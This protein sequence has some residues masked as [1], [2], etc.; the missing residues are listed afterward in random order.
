M[1]FIVK[2]TTFPGL[3][4]LLAP[5]SCRGCG[6]IGEAVCDRCKKYIVKN[7]H[8]FCP[9]CKKSNQN[10]KCPHCKILP[11]TFVVAER[12][13]L[14]DDLIHVYKYSSNRSLKKPLAELLSACMPR[15]FNHSVVIVPLP[16]ISSHIRTRGFDH[17]LLLAKNLAKLRHYKVQKLLLRKRN[18]VQVGADKKTRRLQA[19]EAYQINPKVKIK[20]D[21]TYLLIDDVW[22]TGASMLSAVKKLQQAGVSNIVI[23]ILAVSRLDN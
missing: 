1:S 16:T 6:A 3:F 22:T 23:G 11:P 12:N 17:T 2:N 8:N 13:G 4:D 14:L 19:E 21:T 9:I 10:G 20:N 18:S 15:S 7:H 5:H